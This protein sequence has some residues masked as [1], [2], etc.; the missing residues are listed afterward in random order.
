MPQLTTTAGF[1]VFFEPRDRHG[2]LCD[3][4]L[5]IT[6]IVAAFVMIAAPAFAQ[7][8]PASQPTE[9]VI[10][11]A[12]EGVVQAVPD[13]AWI[14]VGAESRAASAREAQK[15]NTDLMTPVLDKLRAAGVPPDAIRTIA[16]D[17]QYEWDYSSGKRVGRGYLAR[18]TV[19]VRVDAVERVGELLEIAGGSGATSLGGIRFDLKDRS[20]L[21]RDALRQAVADARAKAEAAGAGRVVDR[22][23]RIEERGV[24][25]PPSPE[26]MFRQAAQA[27]A[28]QPPIAAGQIEIRADVVLTVTVK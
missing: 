9:P 24:V 18:N 1:R 5:M 16:Y 11:V 10:V 14:T 20:K 8:A 4:L 26:P 6:T 21:E 23:L 28:A 12:G 13:R 25:P 7:Q 17:V 19:E 3:H 2:R 22:I 27:Q 15:R